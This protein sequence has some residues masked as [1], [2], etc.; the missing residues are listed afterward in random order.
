MIL[1]FM[2]ISDLRFEAMAK[3]S[4]LLGPE[5]EA[6]VKEIKNWLK[7]RGVRDFEP[8]SLFCDQ[9][10]KV[11]LTALLRDCIVLIPKQLGD[12]G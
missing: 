9:L 4:E 10:S 7:L 2:C 8:V 12:G 3:A 1:A 11:C 6:K 5:A